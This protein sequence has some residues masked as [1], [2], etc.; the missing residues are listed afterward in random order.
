[1]TKTVLSSFL[2]F[3][4]S[5]NAQLPFKISNDISPVLSK[6][7]RDYPNNF[8]NIKGDVLEEDPQ[9]TNYACLLNMKDMPPGIITQYGSE[10]DHEYS[11]S[12]VLLQTENYEEA[13]KKFHLFYF[14]IKKTP[15]IIN[16]SSDYTEPD[17]NKKFCSVL[18][19]VAS[20]DAKTKNIVVDLSMQY[21]M[22]E[23]KITVSLY[24]MKDEAKIYHAE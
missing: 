6:V 16:G 11:W 3:S 10:K 22:S 5:A 4:F 7:I 20:G 13:K 2:L 8:S 14:E 15:A 1:M 21:E 12:N 17:E 23:W 18:F 19:N 9:I 24:Q